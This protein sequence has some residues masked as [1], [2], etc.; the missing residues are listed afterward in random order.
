MTA[1]KQIRIAAHP[2]ELIFSE[3]GICS[4]QIGEARFCLTRMNEAIVAFQ[5]KCPHAGADLSGGF[6]D[7]T[8]NV[9]CPLHHYRFSVATGRNVSGEGYFL[10]RYPVHV[11]EEGVFIELI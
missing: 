6:I 4:V 11:G 9:V 8:N 10:K 1:R 3:N 7:K 5:G 2:N